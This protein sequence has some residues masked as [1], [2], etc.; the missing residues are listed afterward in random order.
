L[1]FDNKTLSFT[2]FYKVIQGLSGAPRFRNLVLSPPANHLPTYLQGRGI[3]MKRKINVVAAACVALLFSAVPIFAQEGSMSGNTTPAHHSSMMAN[4]ISDQMFAKEVDRGN[5]TE[6]KLGTLAERKGTNDTVK[7]FGQRMV[8]D[9]TKANEQ[10]QTAASQENITLP[11]EPSA[12]QQQEYQRLSKLSGE[13]FDK[14]YARLMLNV[15][16]HDVA[17]VKREAKYGKNQEIKNWAQLTLPTLEEHLKLARQ[18]YH[19]VESGANS[20]ATG[21]SRH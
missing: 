3:I 14:A 21:S 9:H 20:G 19:S 2:V 10:L 18:M 13:A 16:Q 17:A 11:S 1:P 15:H 7:D 4:R 12:K 6:V 5:L 8:K